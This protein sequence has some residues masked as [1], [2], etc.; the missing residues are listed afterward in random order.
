MKLITSHIWVF[1]L[2]GL[3]RHEVF[4]HTLKC[5]FTTR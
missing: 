4:R 1:T 2:I 5:K 3:L